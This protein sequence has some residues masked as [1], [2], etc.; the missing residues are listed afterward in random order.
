M[1]VAI[2][3]VQGPEQSPVEAGKR[4]VQRGA[5]SSV[6]VAT[7][8]G[9]FSRACG[10]HMGGLL[11]LYMPPFFRPCRGRCLLGTRKIAPCDPG[12]HAAQKTVVGQQSIFDLIG[13]QRLGQYQIGAVFSGCKIRLPAG[14]SQG[15]SRLIQLQFARIFQQECG[16]RPTVPIGH[17]DVKAAAGEPFDYRKDVRAGFNLKLEFS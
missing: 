14:E 8:W 7:R 4:Q 6:S 17:N 16:F 11:W 2:R 3:L 1:P 13:E 10:R 12:L 5:G 9:G 15:E